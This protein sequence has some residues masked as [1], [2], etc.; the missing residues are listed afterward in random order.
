[1]LRSRSNSQISTDNGLHGARKVG[2]NLVHLVLGD[3]VHRVDGADAVL[4]V[5]NLVALHVGRD[6]PRVLGQDLAFRTG[7]DQ[8]PLVLGGAQAGE[9]IA[10]MVRVRVPV[11]GSRVSNFRS[12]FCSRT[13]SLNSEVDGWVKKKKGGGES[14]REAHTCS[15]C[16]SD[17]PV[18]IYPDS[19]RGYSGSGR[20]G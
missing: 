13:P 8:V 9:D 18:W 6:G 7:S 11:V 16:L 1:M 10:G 5:E 17:H 20:L 2:L 15:V 19:T 12:L 14:G 3:H 4:L